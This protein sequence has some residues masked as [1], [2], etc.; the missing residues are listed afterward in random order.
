MNYG[1]FNSYTTNIAKVPALV[2]ANLPMSVGFAVT[3]YVSNMLL[4]AL[5]SMGGTM[6]MVEN[7]LIGGLMKTIDQ[8][9]VMAFRS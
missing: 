4:A 2:M 3:S 8:S 1:S 5:P 7:A 9:V 6:G